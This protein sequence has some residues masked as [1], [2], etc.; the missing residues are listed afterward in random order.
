MHIA[1]QAEPPA[2]ASWNAEPRDLHALG[3]AVAHAD[4]RVGKRGVA[5]EKVGLALAAEAAGKYE[6]KKR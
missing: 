1:W 2:A 4:E 6:R 5:E 3:P